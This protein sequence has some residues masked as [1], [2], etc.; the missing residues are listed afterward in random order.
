MR[1]ILPHLE[2]EGQPQH[3]LYRWQDVVG[4]QNQMMQTC[5]L[6][7]ENDDGVGKAVYVNPFARWYCQTSLHYCCASSAGHRSRL[8]LCVQEPLRIEVYPEGVHHVS[9]G[10]IMQVS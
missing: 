8:V 7:C 10:N 3:H 1:V 4:L 9:S 6:Y 2:C 5:L